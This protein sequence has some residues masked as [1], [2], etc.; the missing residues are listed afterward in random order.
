MSGRWPVAL[1]LGSNLQPE[2]HLAAAMAALAGRF[3]GAVF[4]GT[5]R[6][7]AA[8]F[9]GSDFLNAAALIDSDLSPQALNDW[10]HALEDAQG[11][12]RSAPRWGDRTLDIDI[13]LVG[14]QILEG[15]GHLQVPRDELKHAFVLEPLAAIAPEWVEPRSG[16]TLAQLWAEHRDNRSPPRQDGPCSALP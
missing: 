16:C 11:R 12:D 15:P 14:E 5:Y 13:V 8:G 2:V 10:L 6:Y 9:E 3:P 1:S 4:S 7:P